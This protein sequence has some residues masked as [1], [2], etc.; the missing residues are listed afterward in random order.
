MGIDPLSTALRSAGSHT[1]HNSS[2]SVMAC[3]SLVLLPLPSQAAW[4]ERLAPLLRCSTSCTFCLTHALLI[5]IPKQSIPHVT[6]S[7]NFVYEPTNHA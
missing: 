4:L 5:A 1:A 3:L 7:T 2:Y 6:T